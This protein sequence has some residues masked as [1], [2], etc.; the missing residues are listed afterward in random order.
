MRSTVR[1]HVFGC[2]LLL[3]AGPAWAQT[4]PTETQLNLARSIVLQVIEVLA[5]RA[6]DN[7]SLT[8]DAANRSLRA[9]GATSTFSVPPLEEARRS[10][11]ALF[12]RDVGTCAT[13]IGPLP[14]NAPSLSR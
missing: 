7:L 4:T 14:T 2:A 3:V 12:R 1:F 6:F 9:V 8:A 11:G 13:P 10:G 5:G